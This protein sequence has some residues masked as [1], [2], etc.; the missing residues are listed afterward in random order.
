MYGIH[1]LLMRTCWSI[2]LTSTLSVLLFLPSTP[3]P[4]QIGQATSPPTIPNFEDPALR[5]LTIRCLELNPD[6][7]PASS[8]LLKHALLTESH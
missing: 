7:R 8:D 3:S 5:D 6:D 1:V 2:I 4:P